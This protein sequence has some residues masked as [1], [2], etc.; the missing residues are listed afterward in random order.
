MALDREKT[1]AS[2]MKYADKDQHDKAIREYKKILEQDGEDVRVLMLLATSYERLGKSQDAGDAYYKVYEV[3]RDQGAYQKALAVLKQAQRCLP[4]SDQVAMGLAELYGALG[5]PHEAV[6]QL[7]KCLERAKR[8][9]NDKAY[10]RIL[11]TMV[12]V[13]GENVQTRIRYAELLRKNGEIESAGRQYSLAL[14]Q[15]ASKEKYVD[16]IQTAR[17]YLR[18]DPRDVE[19]LQTLAGI[20][21]RMNRY[22]EA[23]GMLS[24][25]SLDERTPEAFE[26]CITCYM[27][28][29]RTQDAL[30]ELK[31]LAHRYESQGYREDLIES[32]WLRAQK[33]SPNDPEVLSALGEDDVPLLSD[34]ALNVFETPAVS[35]APVASAARMKPTIPVPGA[36]DLD[37]L[38][39]GKYQQALNYYRSSQYQQAQALCQQ[40]IANDERYLPALQLLSQIFEMNGDMPALAQIERKIARAVYE[41]DV[42]EAVRHVLRAEKCTPRAWENFNLMLVFGLTP[43]DYGM[44]AP[45][46]SGVSNPRINV[47]QMNGMP[48]VAEPSVGGGHFAPSPSGLK[49]V[50]PPPL[51]RPGGATAGASPLG[52]AVARTPHATGIPE[53][54]VSGHHPAIPPRHPATTLDIPKPIRKISTGV[55]QDLKNLEQ[56]NRSGMPGFASPYQVH[57]GISGASPAVVDGGNAVD[58]GAGQASESGRP[59]ALGTRDNRPAWMNR[60]QPARAGAAQENLSQRPI[61]GAVPRMPVGTAVSGRATP[62]ATAAVPG[63]V[64]LQ[65][66]GNVPAQQRGDGASTGVRAVLPPLRAGVQP[67][68]G[69]ATGAVS[70]SSGMPAVPPPAAKRPVLTEIPAQ[71]R[72]RVE[73]A[74][75]EVSFYAS[76]NLL[77]DARKLLASLLDE[78]GDIDI[79]HDAK[80]RLGE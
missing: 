9:S 56:N 79:I 48:N 30:R 67:V 20:Y 41:T 75:Q 10:E 44:Q 24:G 33:I 37:R 72:Q 69:S 49:S 63:H 28:L 1:L 8:E 5:L 4:Q 62:V 38:N 43:S 42:D 16:Y 52:H 61:R 73:D 51:R 47:A 17:D 7:E 78:F 70:A 68:S 2:A 15:L 59:Q 76:L 14:A 21:I 22:Q 26:H 54:P 36:R 13:D 34:S 23:L 80:I 57:A 55:M 53:A 18:I 66:Q 12:R 74:L 65:S 58:R 32:V 25:L 46:A 35:A 45:E 19:V 71:D 31:N 40:I 29:G 50:V 60:G 77:D 3:Y 39:D 11:Q 27:K 6:A 64:S